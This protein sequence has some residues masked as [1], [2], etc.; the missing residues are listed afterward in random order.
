VWY[1]FVG[2]KTWTRGPSSR[3]TTSREWR[4]QLVELNTFINRRLLR[5]Q[6]TTTN[7]PSE[8]ASARLTWLLTTVGFTGQVVD[9]GLVEVSSAVMDTHDYH[10]QN[11][12]DELR[13][14]A[15]QSVFNFFL[16]YRESSNDIEM[17]FR[18]DQTSGAEDVSAAFSISNA[19]ADTSESGPV[20]FANPDTEGDQIPDRTA[21][22]YLVQYEG[23]GDVYAT[24]PAIATA[25]APIDLVAPSRFI[26]NAATATDYAED[27][28][29][30]FDTDEE[31]IRNVWVEKL[32]AANLNDVKHGQLI[33]AKFTHGPGWESLR[34]CRVV[35]KLFARPQNTAEEFWRLGLE[36][37]PLGDG[38]PLVPV[39]SEA[40][41][42]S[43]NDNS[44]P[45]PGNEC[46]PGTYRIQWDNSKVGCTPAAEGGNVSWVG[47]PG[48]YTGLQADGEGSVLVDS[49]G[50]VSGVGGGTITFTA[51]LYKNGTPI[52]DVSQ[53]TTG[54]IRFLGWTWAFVD[55]P[56]DV[57]NGDIIETWLQ[58]SAECNILV[59][60]AGTG[61]CANVFAVTG[62]LG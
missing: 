3:T 61:D 57:V 46:P 17:I 59:I 45:N 21:S 1:G 30:R 37:Q 60:P 7:R 9:H 39:E 34:Y 36:L 29:E 6:V 53:T 58:V 47:S 48:A 62:D 23:G 13:D 2:R 18:N 35:R 44:L 41:L 54:G 20:W 32:P 26:K 22:G 5:K 49:K 55:E 16:R 14:I 24:D 52:A 4:L 31:Y 27:L 42:H 40:T 28:L 56:T 51:Y 12:G 25:F 8:T 43:P 15:T 19:L 38:Y 11:G 10:G 50:T 33:K